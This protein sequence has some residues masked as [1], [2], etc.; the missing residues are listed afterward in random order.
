MSAAAA[1][2]AQVIA[3]ARA[4]LGVRWQHQGR[5][6]AG[7]DC[8]GLVIA[9][10]QGLG[11]TEFDTADYAR[12]PDGVTLAATCEA[13]MRRIKRDAMQPGDVVLMRF[14]GHPQHLALLAGYP[15]GGLSVVHAYAPARKVVEHRLDSVWRAH[16]VRAYSLPGVA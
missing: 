1:T 6:R 11:L 16:I 9:V 3:A 14:D 13:Q 15:L 10:A 2:R 7:V 12:H 5:S 4:W 8:A